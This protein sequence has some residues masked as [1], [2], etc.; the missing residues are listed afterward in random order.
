MAIL[1]VEILREAFKSLLD[2]QATRSEN[3]TE[4]TL[5]IELSGPVLKLKVINCIHTHFVNLFEIK[6]KKVTFSVKKKLYESVFSSVYR[7]F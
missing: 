7:S 3:I 6:K 1:R 5:S 2:H 4:D